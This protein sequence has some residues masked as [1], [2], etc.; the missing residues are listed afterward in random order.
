[1]SSWKDYSLFSGYR[2]TITTPTH[3]HTYFPRL[4]LISNL[5][6]PCKRLPLSPP[7]TPSLG[8]HDTDL[9]S[10]TH[11]SSSQGGFAPEALHL[12]EGF[13]VHLSA[14]T[15][16]TK[17]LTMHLLHSPPSQSSCLYSSY[18]LNQAVSPHGQGPSRTRI[19]PPAPSTVPRTQLLLTGM[20]C[21]V[22]LSRPASPSILHATCPPVPL[23][24]ALS[25]YS[26]ALCR[27]PLTL[28]TCSPL[29]PGLCWAQSL[30]PGH[31][32]APTH[33]VV[34]AHEALLV[35]YMMSKGPKIPPTHPQV[36]DNVQEK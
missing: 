15:P 21:S 10:Q 3:T 28:G 14:P 36:T 30:Q 20:W 33:T 26:T 16:Q 19:R 9:L 32:P 13:Q 5:H 1:M 2:A 24:Q 31:S 35:G 6:Y 18:L 12:Q 17:L 25:P 4:T 29:P 22:P 34:S 27:L 7:G 23:S 11:S 8:L